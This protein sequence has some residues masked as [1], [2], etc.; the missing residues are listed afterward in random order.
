LPARLNLGQSS[1]MTSGSVS[2]RPATA[3]DAAAIRD[4]YAP[5]VRETTISFEAD[6]PSTA[7]IRRRMAAGNLRLPWLV[8][9]APRGVA[10]Y[11]YAAPFR[12][13]QAY[14][15]SVETSVYIASHARGR[16]VGR[17]LYER[18]LCDL[19]GLGYVSAYAGIALPNDASVR[20][21]EAAGFTS[22]GVFP[23]AGYKS[24]GW[25]DVGWWAI[26]L[27][28]APAMPKPPLPWR[29]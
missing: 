17:A 10:G 6:P 9:E 8:A 16:G 11:A 4:I 18:L 27:R 5:I 2:V 12:S 20:L 1:I 15:W 29:P 21:H 25:V 7:E 22:I 24:G 23:A 26:K 14:R 28:S 3:R 13:R 19:R